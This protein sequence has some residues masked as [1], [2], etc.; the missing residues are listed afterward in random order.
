MS[1]DIEEKVFNAFKE[2]LELKDGVDR[3][4][5]EYNVTKGWDS[6]GHMSLIANLEEVFDCM[7][8]T[9]HILDMST[10]GKAVEIMSE[11]S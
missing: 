10:F 2:S 9:D 7:L 1:A 6:V 4:A 8:E 11:Y 5:L 3:S